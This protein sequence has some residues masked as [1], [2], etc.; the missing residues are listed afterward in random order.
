MKETNYIWMDGKIIPWAD[1]KIHVLTHSLHYGSAVF[2]GLRFYEAEEGP[3]IFRLKE[4]TT[5]LFYS[6]DTIKLRIPFSED[7]INSAII[8]TVKVNE[9]KTG[10][11]RPLAFFGYGK[12]GLRP[13]GSPVN[14]S[15]AVWPW[16][17]YLGANPINVKISPYIRIHPQSTSMDAKIT[18]NYVNSTFAGVDAI[19]NGYEEALL[20]DF[21]GNVAEGPGENIF[22]V[23]NDIIYTPPKGKILAG[24]TRD[25]IITIAEDFGYSVQEKVLKPED[26]Y[27]ADEAFF[28]GTAAEVTAIASLDD[29]P[30]KFQTGP[31]TKKLS[32]T[33]LS[34]VKGLNEKY[35]NWLTIVR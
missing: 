19:S 12:M 23:K 1:A 18:G 21:E 25:S 33:F 26:V 32:D 5:R 13:T 15:I 10:Y 29:H 27:D 31:I 4:H 6:A 3:A 30:M 24:I 16:D 8:E 17:S 28:T 35:K 34:I 20:L 9:I 2:E 22:I 14:L 7:E 11:I